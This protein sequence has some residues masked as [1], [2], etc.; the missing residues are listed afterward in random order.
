MGKPRQ[1]LTRPA[2]KTVETFI[3]NINVDTINDDKSDIILELMNNETIYQIGNIEASEH[4]VD[5][6]WELYDTNTIIEVEMVN[7]QNYSILR[8]LGLYVAIIQIND[9]LWVDIDSLDLE[10]ESE[11]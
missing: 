5:L 10:D 9:N 2:M 4:N 7:M 6:L 1:Y 8:V 11:E 3:K